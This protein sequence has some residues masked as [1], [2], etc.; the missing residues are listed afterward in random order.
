MKTFWD[1]AAREEI[2]GRVDRLRADSAP[3]WGKFNAAGMLAHLNDAMRM[4]TGDL[5]VE[6]KATPFRYWPIK[7][8]IIYVVP[9]PQ[10]APTAPEL[11]ARTDAARFEDEKG[12]FRKVVDQLVAKAAGDTWPEHPA[13]GRLTHR[14]WGVLEYKHADH[15]LRQFGV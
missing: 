11:L 6:P 9:F 13:F 12:A 1:A 2:C 5:P 7:Q 3:Q 10:G 4:A 8:L 14:A 15:H